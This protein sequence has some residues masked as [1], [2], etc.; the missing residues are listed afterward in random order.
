M[1]E[2]NV[3]NHRISFPTV[4]AAYVLV[5]MVLQMF[6]IL[7]PS[8]NGKITMTYLWPTATAALALFIY[9][10]H[11]KMPNGAWLL[12]AFVGWTFFTC[13]VNGDAYL[14]YNS[15]FMLGV[16]MSCGVF[17]PTFML[18]SAQKRKKAL[19]IFASVLV[20]AMTAFAICGMIVV[21]TNQSMRIPFTDETLNY[22]INFAAPS[23]LSI[24]GQHPNTSGVHFSYALFA[25]IY[26]GSRIKEK[27]I[28]VLLAPCCL[29]LFIGIVLTDSRT[30]L[31]S[32]SIGLGM[33]NFLALM[34]SVKKNHWIKY[35]V[36]SA[37]MILTIVLVFMSFSGAVRV[38]ASL[39]VSY[40]KHI[41][42]V[43]IAVVEP[44]MLPSEAQIP[45]QTV[46]SDVQAPPVTQQEAQPEVV[47]PEVRK[48]GDLHTLST[49]MDIYR[50]V[51]PAMQHRPVTLLVGELASKALQYAETLVTEKLYS[52]HNALLQVLMITGIPGLILAIAFLWKLVKACVSLFFS[53]KVSFGISMLAIIP[54][55]ILVNNITEASL[56]VDDSLI[57]VLFFLW[58]GAVMAYDCELKRCNQKEQTE[59][60]S[61]IG[62]KDEETL[63]SSSKP[64]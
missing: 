20:A 26:L 21:I 10:S 54:T 33:L 29:A 41:E 53:K 6:F 16:I 8:H 1:K 52:M 15:R 23:R 24:F 31:I 5:V 9:H 43:E 32:T 60:S 18:M 28:W 48:V 35:G 19:I 42:E 3:M 55:V 51:I 30:V 34:R 59:A 49:R 62:K 4:Y 39:T 56:F 2:N 64:Q 40:S 47:L 25:A 13:V 7:S 44:D 14:T 22:G 50:T 27:W 17:Y 36:C 58:S 57:N 38:L 63:L 46:Q 37:A 61:A 11:R 45:E 12:I